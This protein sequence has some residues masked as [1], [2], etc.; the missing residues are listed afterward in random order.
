MNKLLLIAAFITVSCTAQKNAGG[1]W[2]QLFDGKTLNGWKVGNNKETFSVDSGMII[3]H[4]RTA[5]LFYDGD[6]NNHEFANFHFKTDVLTRPGANSGIYFH[7]RY[8]EGGWPVKG[9]EVQ[10]NNSQ[11]DWRRTGSIY[12]IADVREVFVKDNEW[13][14]Q[15]IIV[16]GKH[17]TIKLNGK[18]INEYTEPEN[19]QRPENMKERLINSGTFALQGHDPNSR[20]CYKNIMVKILP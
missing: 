20:V 15:E 19:V 9:M 18:T 8:Q 7:T 14:T 1:D 3:V 10:V 11:S 2:K 12:A 4:G 6:V 17:V 5:H 13:Y 16:Q